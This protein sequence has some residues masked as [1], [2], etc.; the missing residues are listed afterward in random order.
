MVEAD[1]SQL[2]VVVQGVL[3]RDSQLL[4]D[5]RNRIDFHCKR[6]A[7][8]PKY[9]ITYEEVL[10]IIKDE[11]HPDHKLWKERRTNAKIFSFQRAYGAGAPLIAAF[12]GMTV[13][14]VEAL[15]AADEATYPGVVDFNSNVEEAVKE[16]A[17]WF[18]DP[19][20]QGNLHRS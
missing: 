16:S 18:F 19:A 13:E 8:Q 15:I 20:N 7:I 9:G 4:E 2:E 12:T 3:S 10:E 6:V 14:E 17:D 1:Y 11:D 5:L